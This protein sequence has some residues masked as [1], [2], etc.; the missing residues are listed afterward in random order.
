MVF[1]VQTCSLDTMI[2]IHL[3]P[4]SMPESIASVVGNVND[5]KPN[6]VKTCVTLIR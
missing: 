6:A 4:L 2:I 1:P 3:I 5:I